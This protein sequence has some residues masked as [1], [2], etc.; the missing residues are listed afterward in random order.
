MENVTVMGISP[1]K[2][3]YHLVGMNEG[4]CGSS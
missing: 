1:R 3:V 4:E 2:H